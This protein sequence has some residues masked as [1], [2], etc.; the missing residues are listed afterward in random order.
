MFMKRFFIFAAMLISLTVK[1]MADPDG[2]QPVRPSTDQI[3]L[4]PQGM[5]DPERTIT[6]CRYDFDANPGTVELTCYG[7]G[8]HTELYIMTPDGLIIDQ[9]LIDTDI[10]QNATLLLPTEAGTYYL[11]LNSERYFGSV[12]IIM[13]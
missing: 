2:P 13:E 4:I 8:N 3:I 1:G 7:T 6:L 11:I 5:F 10:M 12:E 9:T